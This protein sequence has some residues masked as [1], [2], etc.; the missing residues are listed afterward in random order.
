MLHAGRGCRV[1]SDIVA[2][3]FD[4]PVRAIIRDILD[5]LDAAVGL[6]GEAYMNAGRRAFV[7]S[8]IRAHERHGA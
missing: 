2:E 6:Q 1:V 5:G 3:P 7:D 4:D 8:A